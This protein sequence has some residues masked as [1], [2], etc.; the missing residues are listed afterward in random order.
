M[1]DKFILFLY[2]LGPLPPAGF[3]R[4]HVDVPE[5]INIKLSTKSTNQHD[6]LGILKY[7]VD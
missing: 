3:R 6:T 5:Y 2:L 7:H 1:L 4:Y